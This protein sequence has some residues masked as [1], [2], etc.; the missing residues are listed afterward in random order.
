MLAECGGAV[1]DGSGTGWIFGYGSLIWR[2]D[3][4]HVERRV[5]RVGGWRRRFWQGSPDHRGQPHAPGRVAT[6]VAE[7]EAVC[8]G[9]AYRV[10]EADWSGVVERLDLRESGGFERHEVRVALREPDG[11]HI[12]ALTYV[13]GPG[14]PNFLGPA[15][16][17]EMLA[18]MRTARGKSGPN[19][20]YILR[21]AESLRALDAPDPHLD[22]L[23]QALL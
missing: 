1:S 13:A 6:L 20:E 9:V 12:R 4:P 10:A 21:L 7:P 11:S 18:Q 19:T 8:W 5:G 15:P 14:N 23:A 17:D 3:F 16:L 22:H 2:P